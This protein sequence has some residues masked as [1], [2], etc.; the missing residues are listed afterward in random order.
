MKFNR[1]HLN[2]SL[3]G[4]FVCLPGGFFFLLHGNIVLAVL[5][6]LLTVA[7]IVSALWIVRKLRE[8]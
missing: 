8:Q 5:F 1:K 4:I 3:F 7:E 2:A 6:V